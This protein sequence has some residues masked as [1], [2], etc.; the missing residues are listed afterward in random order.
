MDFDRKDKAGLGAGTKKRPRGSI[1]TIE[2]AHPSH[3]P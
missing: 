1:Q 3:Q 2:I